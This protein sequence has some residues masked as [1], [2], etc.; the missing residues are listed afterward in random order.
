MSDTWDKDTVTLAF[1]LKQSMGN[2]LKVIGGFSK[3]NMI[4]LM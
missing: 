2:S 4:E 3:L 1:K